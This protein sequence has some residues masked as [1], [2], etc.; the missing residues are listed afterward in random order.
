[1]SIL[2]KLRTGRQHMHCRDTMKQEPVCPPEYRESFAGLAA[3]SRRTRWEELVLRIFVLWVGL[4]TFST[5]AHVVAGKWWKSTSPVDT[6]GEAGEVAFSLATTGTFANPYPS[7]PTG[8]TAQTAPGYP[9]LLSRVILLF[10]I[11]HAAWWAIHVL[12]IAAF[13]L[14]WALMPWVARIWEL[15]AA[16]GYLAAVLG[17]LLPIPG[18]F[19]KWEAIFVGLA[20][21]VLAGLTGLLLAKPSN[22]L[23]WLLTATL[24]GLGLLFSPVLLP[25]WLAWLLLPAYLLRHAVSWGRVMIL[26]LVPLLV[27]T[28]WTVRNYRVF[29]HLFLIRDSMGQALRFSNNDC[30]TGWVKEDL[31]SGCLGSMNPYDNLAVAQ[32]LV[33]EGEYQFNMDHLHDG[34]SWI[35][36]NPGKFL[37][38]TGARIRFFWF[39]P[40]MQSEGLL[41]IVN[42]IAIWGAT[43]LSIPGLYLIFVWRRQAGALLASGLLL[44]PLVYYLA[45]VDLRYRYPILW[46]TVLAA[47]A[48]LYEAGRAGLRK[49]LLHSHIESNTPSTH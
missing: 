18:I 25:L 44:Y 38:F 31:A 6:T 28:P 14:Q 1:M 47:A 3:K 36:Q 32:R 10:G 2:S 22:N 39:P 34:I 37:A 4:F 8:P 26:A 19:F 23:L 35:E 40:V 13:T 29:H 45:Q 20:L 7:M 5:V 33:R 21:T 46:M 11:G 27:V 43:A 24:W 15:P 17:G 49:R 16:I 12:T 48:A 41:G 30:T 9:Y 42:L